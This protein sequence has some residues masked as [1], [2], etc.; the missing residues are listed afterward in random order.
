MSVALLK[1]DTGWLLARTGGGGGGSSNLPK[2]I[3]YS[4]LDSFVVEPVVS[5]GEKTLSFG[6][7]EAIC[8]LR[9]RGK[10]AVKPRK[11]YPPLYRG[12]AVYLLE[13]DRRGAF[14]DWA[15]GRTDQMA[16]V[17]Q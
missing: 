12:N 15:T 11:G 7:D 10:E 4:N 16:E 6:S 9:L 14:D 3:D 17:D 1:T 5:P 8:L 2:D 13:S